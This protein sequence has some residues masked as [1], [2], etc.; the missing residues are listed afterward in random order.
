MDAVLYA[1]EM[2]LLRRSSSAQR[3]RF[4]RIRRA[5]GGADP[6][7]ADRLQRAERY[8]GRRARRGQ[9][10]TQGSPRGQKPA[11]DTR[12]LIRSLG[13]STAPARYSMSTE[14]AKRELV[15]RAAAGDAAA[16]AYRR[17][18]LPKEIEFM[19]RL[20]AQGDFRRAQRT[21]LRQLEKEFERL[22]G[23]R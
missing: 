23:R 17:R 5:Q 1:L 15:R 7:F 21:Y 19:R 6:R 11:T 14:K 13:G 4:G 22:G 9:P 20:E 10:P 8:L 16:V 12:K 18:A 3:S 2:K